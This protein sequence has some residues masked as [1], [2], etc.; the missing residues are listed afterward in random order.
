[1][2]RGPLSHPILL[3]CTYLLVLWLYSAVFI[4]IMYMN[5]T[6]SFS[7]LPMIQ[8]STV[9]LC[10]PRLYRQSLFCFCTRNSA[11]RTA[12]SPSAYCCLICGGHPVFLPW[13]Q[14]AQPL[15]VLGG[16]AVRPF[17]RNPRTD[18]QLHMAHPT[19]IKIII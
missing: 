15:Q 1:M 10:C 18:L 11:P 17:G 4:L 19:F 2:C 6:F 8:S 9:L 5:E 12:T 3:A 13:P 7:V 16:V 14:P